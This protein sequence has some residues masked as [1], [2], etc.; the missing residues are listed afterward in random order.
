MVVVSS[1]SIEKIASL[2]TVVLRSSRGRVFSV[3]GALAALLHQGLKLGASK[4]SDAICWADQII[5]KVPV[6]SL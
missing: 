2:L 4:V 3:H 6:L 5:A 1:A